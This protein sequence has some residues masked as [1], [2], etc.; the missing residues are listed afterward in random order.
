MNFRKLDSSCSCHRR[1]PTH[2]VE[3][4]SQSEY[5][6]V[7]KGNTA[8]RFEKIGIP[9]CNNHWT[10]ILSHNWALFCIMKYCLHVHM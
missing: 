5:P 8:W 1:L 3:K 9:L 4:K 2:T 6:L 7:S 10:G